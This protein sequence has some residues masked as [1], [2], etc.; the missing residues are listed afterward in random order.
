MGITV[1]L[2]LLFL[3]IS[4]PPLL[5]HLFSAFLA[6]YKTEII[7]AIQELGLEL[8]RQIF[9]IFL[10]LFKIFKYYNIKIKFK[11]GIRWKERIAKS[12]SFLRVFYSGIK[13]S[14]IYI[15]IIIK[16]NNLLNFLPIEY[17]IYNTLW[18]FS[19]LLY[20]IISSLS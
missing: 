14:Y 8:Q 11:N 10:I 12:S 1:L 9:E 16:I 2:L 7:I 13:V 19:L 4:P 17:L 15:L 20:D 3:V 18:S 5:I 6:C